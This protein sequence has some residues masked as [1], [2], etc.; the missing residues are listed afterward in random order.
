MKK[1]S[2]NILVTG[3]ASGIG[4]AACERFR[5]LGHE[6]WALDIAPVLDS[7]PERGFT[8]DITSEASMSA[9]ADALRAAGV[10]LDVIVAAAGIHAMASLVEGDFEKLERLMEINLIG[11]MRTVHALHPLLSERGRIVIV[12]SEVATLDPL[13]FN[14]LYSVSKCALE[15]YSQ[16]L[17]QE[18]N[19][20]GQ[21][22][23]TVRPGAIETPLA[24]G[25]IRATEALADSTEL[26][27]RQASRFSGIAKRFMGKPISPDRLSRVI[28][29]AALSRHPR[30]GYNKHRSIGLLLLNLL[31]KRMQCSVIRILLG[32]SKKN[33]N[34]D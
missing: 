28:A 14:G 22:V 23:V 27:K 10:R 3:A 8:A 13:P 11:T 34:N 15:A 33:A 6:V 32:K 19:L 7:D 12:T 2:L 24:A 21:R 17:R 20:L 30:L 25:S 26:Y 16:A 29:R 4:R 18:L 5:A 9:V 1:E 31:P